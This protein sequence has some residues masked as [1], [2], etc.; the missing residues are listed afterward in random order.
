[1]L[2][3]A[4]CQPDTNPGAS[5]VDRHV[6]ERLGSVVPML[7]D[8]GGPLS[9]DLLYEGNNALMR[10]GLG[11]GTAIAERWRLTAQR[12]R[13]LFVLRDSMWNQQDHVR[14]HDPVAPILPP[15]WILLAAVRPG[16]QPVQ[17]FDVD[18]D[19]AW[20]ALRRPDQLFGG[21]P[22][23]PVLF[24]YA[25]ADR[26]GADNR[27]GAAITHAR[28]TL[29]ALSA[30]TEALRAA[31]EGGWRQVMTAGADII[32]AGDRT[33]FTAAVR[34]AH[35]IPIFVENPAPHEVG[36]G[37]GFVVPGLD[38]GR[39][40]ERFLVK[41]ICRARLRDGDIALER[42]DLSDPDAVERALE[43]LQAVIPPGATER[44]RVW[45]WVTGRLDPDR[46]LQGEGPLDYVPAFRK[47]I[48]ALPI[49]GE[50]LR[51]FAK[52]ME[53]LDGS[54]TMRLS[55]YGQADLFMSVDG[56]TDALL[57]AAGIDPP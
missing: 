11:D 54:F 39:D 27:H 16:L 34:R 7:T 17:A 29:R 2:A 28:L 25:T 37:K 56:D 52:P 26:R 10:N 38:A 50:R 31:A 32:A 57:R 23:S 44:T 24:R 48:E 45:L 55:A 18:D 33:Y 4:A 43:V 36:E 47:R 46:K 19:A 6:P 49:D 3:L 12:T 40:K 20:T 51:L 35:V 41:E 8:P 15:S 22:P 9:S 5:P 1:M 42:Y 21:Y 30:H 14:R 53:P 13:G